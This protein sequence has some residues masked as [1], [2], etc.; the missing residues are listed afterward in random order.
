MYFEYKAMIYAL[1][2]QVAI[3]GKFERKHLDYL[4][5]RS[6]SFGVWFLGA[7][8]MSVVAH[9]DLA[10]NALFLSKVLAT[11]QCEEMTHMEDA[12]EAVFLKNCVQV[13]C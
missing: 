9:M 6:D 11:K 3:M 12:W 10:T 7:S 2:P 13:C 4:P 8:F 5:S 1:P